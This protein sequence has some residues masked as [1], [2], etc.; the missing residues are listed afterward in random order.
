MTSAIITYSHIDVNLG[1]KSILK[2]VNLSIAPGEMVYVTGV[3]GSGKT[4]LLRTIYADVPVKGACAQVLGF[5]LLS[6]QRN[7]VPALRRKLGI[8]FQDYKL[9]Q[10]CNVL[11]N[12]RLVLRATGH[13]DAK[14]ADKHIEEVLEMVSMGR[15]AYD[16]PQQLSGGEQQR[17]ALARALL[18]N[19][20][21]ILA[22]EPTG[23][24]DEANENIV[25]DLFAQ[26]HK[27]GTTLI[28]V[29][30]DP[31]VAEAAQRT[32]V[33]EHGRVAREVINENFGK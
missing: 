12:L 27:E 24:L 32:I 33:L 1:T 29:T 9:L 11:N 14:E 16:M 17:I 8:V 2:D 13:S 6:L 7:E 4:S 31:E 30:H 22:D 23:N 20:E 19:P 28:V 3:V 5:D 21:L 10:D 18:N 25:L 26:L 15:H